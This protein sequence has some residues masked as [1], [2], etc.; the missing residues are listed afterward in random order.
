VWLVAALFCTLAGLSTTSFAI[1]RQGAI[2]AL[3]MHGRSD[4]NWSVPSM[5]DSI[6]QAGG[7]SGAHSLAA[8]FLLLAYVVPLLH[9]SALLVMWLVRFTP[10][11]QQQWFRL[12]EFLDAWSGLD[13]LFF[14]MFVSWIGVFVAGLFRRHGLTRRRGQ[15]WRASQRASWRWLSPGWCVPLLAPRTSGPPNSPDLVLQTKAIRVLAPQENYVLVLVPSL[16][17]GFWWLL[18]ALLCEKLLSYFLVEL[19]AVSIAQ[20]HVK[21][22]AGQ[23]GE[24]GAASPRQLLPAELMQFSPAARYVGV[25][26]MPAG[27]FYAGLPRGL[28]HAFVFCGFM[29]ERVAVATSADAAAHEEAGA[30]REA[31]ALSEDS[32]RDASLAERRRM[33]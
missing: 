3:L 29:Q 5:A 11:R 27:P 28:W 17:T 13:V 21:D 16:E 9:I 7:P 33:I 32:Q 26:A 1:K 18:A 25:S 14:A 2:P 8:V 15:A 30:G 24:E 6:V 12:T 19:S 31:A 22:R 23:A 20:R 4:Q 10:Q